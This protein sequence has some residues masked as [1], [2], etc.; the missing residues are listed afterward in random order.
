M[1]R[2]LVVGSQLHIAGQQHVHAGAAIAFD[3]QGLAVS[4]TGGLAD[5]LDM[6]VFVR[7]QPGKY[8]QFLQD[9]S[10]IVSSAAKRQGLALWAIIENE[11]TY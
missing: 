6:T 1:N 11:V 10:D 2:A 4:K 3:K 7:G 8:G 9:G 5:I